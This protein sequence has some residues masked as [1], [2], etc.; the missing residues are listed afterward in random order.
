MSLFR[1]QDYEFRVISAVR[2]RMDLLIDVFI[3]SSR[4]W[5]DLFNSLLHVRGDI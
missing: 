1:V 4:Y 3:D 5:L 2:R